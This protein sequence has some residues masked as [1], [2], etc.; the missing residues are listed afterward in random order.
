MA[1]TATASGTSGAGAH[2]RAR[3]ALVARIMAVPSGIGV[4]AAAADF[5]RRGSGVAWTTGAGLALFGCVAV[6]LASLGVARLDHGALR[7][8]LVVL[9]LLG[10]ALT[11]LAA[12]FLESPLVLGMML[13][14]LV[15]WLVLV[16][17]AR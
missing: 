11:A 7:T 8:T 9:I 15:C 14:A 6:T 2:Q 3:E 12:W 1:Q 4:I 16:L 17:V 5:L 13:A 10:E